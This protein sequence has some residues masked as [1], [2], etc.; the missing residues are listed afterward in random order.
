MRV[1]FS[2]D[3]RIGRQAAKSARPRGFFAG[4]GVLGGLAANLACGAAPCPKA[5]EPQ[6]V[7]R[8]ALR[9]D[10]GEDGS[11]MRVRF[12]GA[13]MVTTLIARL[14]AALRLPLDITVT[15]EVCG[16]V[17]AYYDPESRRVVLCD[18]LLSGLAT[19]LAAPG[20]D[21]RMVASAATGA[22]VFFLLHELGHALIHTLDL[23]AV[24][25]EEDA[26]DQLATV[27]LVRELGVGGIET[28]LDGAL[29]LAELDAAEADVLAAEP[30]EA[31]GSPE[32]VYWDEHSFGEQRFYDIVCLVYGSNP[33]GHADLVGQDY[34]PPE[35]ADICPDEWDVVSRAWERLLAPYRVA[36]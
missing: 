17:N 27:L 14:D 8:G 33:D 16:E 3:S 13:P 25:R 12:C 24:G 20:A 9:L 2:S 21:P 28:A 15:F 7:D 36:A 30:G 35:R 4:L 11:G 18:E 32:P 31:E 19:T 29:G 23:P 1:S 6:A 10:C 5:A 26:V 22:T 34:L